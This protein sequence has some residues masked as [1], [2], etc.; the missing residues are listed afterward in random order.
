MKMLEG[1]D[2]W[3]VVAIG[4]LTVNTVITRCFFFIANKRWTLPPW[5]QRGLHYAPIAALAGVIVPEVLMLNGHLLSTWQDARPYAVAAGASWY[6]W[7]RGLLGTLVCGMTVYL[8]LR[9]G[10]GW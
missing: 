5:A 3:T 8:G 7:R 6:F 2:L 1:T 9:L 10:L 4:L